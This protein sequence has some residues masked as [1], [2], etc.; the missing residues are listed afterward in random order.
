MASLRHDVRVTL[1]WAL[2]GLVAV[3]LFCVYVMRDVSVTL[4]EVV[5]VADHIAAGDLS[6]RVQ[7]AAN[8]APMAVT[9]VGYVEVEPLD[10]APS[11]DGTRADLPI[12]VVVGEGTSPTG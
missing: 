12:T 2:V 9:L 11:K 10:P 1:A 6:V 5:T 7:A 4:R 8:V 3:S